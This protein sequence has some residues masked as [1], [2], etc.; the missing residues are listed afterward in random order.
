LTMPAQKPGASKQNYRTPVA[1]LDAVKT[2]LGITQF[3]CDI[4]ADHENAVAPLYF[5]KED[6]ALAAPTWKLGDGW[7]WMNPEYRAIAPWVER[8]ANES[9]LSDTRTAILIP[10]SVGSNWWAKHVHGIA[11][12]LLLNGRIPFMPEKPDW[13]YPKDCALLLYSPEY[14]AC[15]CNG[16][17]PYEV[18]NWRE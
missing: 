1:F 14:T 11:H 5:T 2:R 7:N 18:W 17:W 15:I 12:V 13:L 4:C 16:D 9:V 8:A 3:D 10:A 6:S